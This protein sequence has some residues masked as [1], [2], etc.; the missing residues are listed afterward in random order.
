MIESQREIE[1]T[2]F[3]QP[4]GFCKILFAGQVFGPIAGRLKIC[5]K[6]KVHNGDIFLSLNILKEMSLIF[7]QKLD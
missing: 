7:F 6:Q 5:H 1:A 2:K 4:Q 3:C